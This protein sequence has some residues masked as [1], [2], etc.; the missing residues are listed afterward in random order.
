M[1]WGDGDVSGEQESVGFG[2]GREEAEAER[3]TGKLQGRRRTDRVAGRQGQKQGGII[4][5]EA[6]WKQKHGGEGLKVK[7]RL[8]EL[9]QQYCISTQR[10]RRHSHRQIREGERA[11]SAG[12][13]A[14]FPASTREADTPSPPSQAPSAARANGKQHSFHNCWLM[15]RKQLQ[16]HRDRQ[17][18]L[19]RQ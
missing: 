5:R 11:K 1:G 2:R 16:N 15:H 18:G 13:T 10:P 4:G 14:L 9:Q 3:Q 7:T 8:A 19:V 17:R 12:Q 6:D